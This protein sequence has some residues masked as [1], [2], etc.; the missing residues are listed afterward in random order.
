MIVQDH[1][2]NKFIMKSTFKIRKMTVDDID[3]CLDVH[4]L[5]FPVKYS[6]N[7][8]TEYCNQEFLSL[9]L[10][11]N[12]EEGQEKIIGVSTTRRFWTSKFSYD[13]TSYLATFGILE[14]Y[15]KKGLGSY[16]LGVTL[17]IIGSYYCCSRFSLH[18]LR[19]N[20]L[21]HFYEK[22]GLE[23][24]QVIP[25]Y[26]S[27]T[28]PRPDAVVM[29]CDPRKTDFNID[30]RDD[31]VF[32]DEVKLMLNEKQSVGWLAPWFNKP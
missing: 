19:K 32:D 17:K 11:T 26:Y 8:I 22:A 7:E 23:A 30:S 10:T 1:L 16:L 5:L 21:L 12:D 18:M 31:I 27:F 14:N 20:E 4:H 28:D 25:E 13:R 15:R 29:Q 24:I 3:E 6:K 2:N 9:L